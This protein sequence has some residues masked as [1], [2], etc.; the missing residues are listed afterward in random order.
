MIVGIDEVGRGA[1]AG[2]LVVGAV[3][4]GGET[5]EG[6]TDSK[7][8]TKKMREKL[9]LEIR[10]KALGVGIGWVS[11]KQIDVIGLS[12]ALKLASRKALQGI[13]HDFKEIIIDGTIALID[14]PRVTL[15]KKADLLIPS[16]SAASIVAKVARDNYMKHVDGVFPGYKFSGHVGYGTAAHQSAIE[17]LGVTPL[18]RLSFKPLSKYALNASTE[19]PSET[20]AARV[21]PDAQSRKTRSEAVS[22]GS[23][24][25]RERGPVRARATSKQIGN[26]GEDVAARYLWQ[27]GHNIIDRNWRTKFCEIDIVSQ[28]GDT[29][30]FTEVKYRKNDVAGGGLAAITPKKQRQMKFAAELYALNHNLKDINLRLMAIDVAGSPPKVKTSLEL[31]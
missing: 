27:L 5:I 11:A 6:L 17:E 29:V 10:Q 21:F 16:V 25:G 2:P 9:D 1:W 30:Y 14:D 20:S 28:A 13:R 3:L 23:T 7:K 18:H 15:M 19:K 26:T 22:E 31:G 8:L 24:E 4:L 12:E